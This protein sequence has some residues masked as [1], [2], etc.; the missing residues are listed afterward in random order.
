MFLDAF[1]P[2]NLAILVNYKKK[3]KSGGSDELE[4]D[5]V[6]VLVR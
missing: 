1:P 4:N 3:K 6:V 2:M 5:L